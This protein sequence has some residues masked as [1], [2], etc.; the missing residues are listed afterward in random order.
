M[1]NRNFNK[2]LLIGEAIFT[3]IF[4]FLGIFFYIHA[5][6]L[7]NPEGTVL[8][9]GFVVNY[10]N[11]KIYK[12]LGLSCL[13]G[14]LFGALS[15]MGTLVI[16]NKKAKSAEKAF[17]VLMIL[18]AVNAP[19]LSGADSVIRLMNDNKVE[20]VQVTGRESLP[21]G[22]HSPPTYRLS[23]SN[24]SRIKA[25]YEEYINVPDGATY[26]VIMNGNKCMG[27]FSSEEYTLPE[28]H[29]EQ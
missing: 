10:V 13:Y 3:G 9:S 26:Y 14:A 12:D 7:P 20:T 11:I 23:F 18:F 28:Y 25:T 2:A 24:G 21:G 27:S 5:S 8:T 17:I 29:F 6:I 4:L 22:R 1:E 16:Q 19:V 15:L